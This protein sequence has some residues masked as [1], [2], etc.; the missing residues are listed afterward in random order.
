M[1]AALGVVYRTIAAFQRR[2]AEYRRAVADSGAV[3]LVERFGCALHLHVR[4][5]MLM[6]D[7][8]NRRRVPRRSARG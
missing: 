8:V 5:H 7:G 3:T 6:P 1:G 2:K 4:F